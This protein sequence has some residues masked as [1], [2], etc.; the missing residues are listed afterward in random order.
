MELNPDCMRLI[1]K[2]CVQN[3]DYKELS[4][5]Q[6]SEK[7]VFLETLYACNELKN[8]TKK[9]IMYSV[10]KLYEY[11]YIILAHVVPDK[12]QAYIDSCTIVDVT[13]RG[14]DFYNTIQEDNIWNKTKQVFSKVGNH[15]LKFI[16]DTAQKIAV[17]SAKQ[18]ITA[19]V[20]P[21]V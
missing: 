2:Y 4:M 8:F 18:L 11:K 7:Y 14:H 15:T 13:V 10:M 1:L 16:E 6:W 21:Y 12:G 19:A 17:E 5:N 20:Q 9:D 3:I